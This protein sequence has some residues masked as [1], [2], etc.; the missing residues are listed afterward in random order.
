M[1]QETLRN[2]LSAIPAH[3][4]I[5]ARCSHEGCEKE[6][7]EGGKCIFHCPKDDWFEVV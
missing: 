1:K 6:V 4:G 5:V 2:D 3:T 7:F